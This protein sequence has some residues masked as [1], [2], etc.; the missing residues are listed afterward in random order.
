MSAATSVALI[1]KDHSAA[2]GSYF[3]SVRTPGMKDIRFGLLNA[4]F[5]S[6]TCM[7][8]RYYFM[9]IRPY[10]TA[11]FLA[12]AAFSGLFS[13][14]V[15]NEDALKK[16]TAVER[17]LIMSYRW[18]MFVTFLLSTHTVVISTAAIVKGLHADYDPMSESGYMLLKRS[19]EYEFV[20]SRWSYLVSLLAF[21]VAVTNRILFEFELFT[22]SEVR[23]TMGV[24]V[25]LLMSG[26][27]LHLVSFLNSTLYCW[28]NLGE[29]TTALLK[30]HTERVR[31]S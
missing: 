8:T 1:L 19:F 7:L 10:Y 2:V 11:S 26:L 30:V 23:R 4:E 24:A 25:C 28:N 15:S 14:N 12:G 6:K 13:L 21:L 18:A 31:H 16:D 3:N 20:V 22:S 27:I 9:L 29:M 17:F 5:S